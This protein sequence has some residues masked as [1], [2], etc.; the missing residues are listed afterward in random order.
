MDN[1]QFELIQPV[2]GPTVYE[3]FLKRKG[4]EL[5]H[6]KQVVGDLPKAAAEYAKMRSKVIRSGR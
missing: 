3:D 5:H 1:T 4:K 6:I 2:K